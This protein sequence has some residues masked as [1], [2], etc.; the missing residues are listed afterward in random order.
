MFQTYILRLTFP[1]Y[2]L[3]SSFLH[4]WKQSF[5]V[6]V[7][8][9]AKSTSYWKLNLELLFQ[10]CRT[11]Q[12]ALVNEVNKALSVL[13]THVQ[14]SKNFF[15]DYF[16]EVSNKMLFKKFSHSKSC[17]FEVFSVA[18]FHRISQFYELNT[19]WCWSEEYVEM[20]HSKFALRYVSNASPRFVRHTG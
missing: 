11:V 7:R 2:S 5:L 15:V 18:G 13:P 9:H 16:C 6:W 14:V 12:V 1:A 10:L 19:F 4:V 17:S 20:G 3:V 8:C